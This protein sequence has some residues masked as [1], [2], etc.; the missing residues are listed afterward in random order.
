MHNAKQQCWVNYFQLYS[1]VDIIEQP[2]GRQ[3]P[4]M[5]LYMWV[6]VLDTLFQSP[7]SRAEQFARTHGE[8]PAVVELRQKDPLCRLQCGGGHSAQAGL[9]EGQR[10]SVSREQ[11]LAEQG[12]IAHNLLE[13]QAWA[14]QGHLQSK[15]ANALAS[16]AVWTRARPVQVCVTTTF[17]IVHLY[18]LHLR[19]LKLIYFIIP[20]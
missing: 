10:R 13:T 8:Q 3:W 9:Q 20:V 6:T 16:A 1:Y 17:W 11:V 2:S 4:W 19:V 15:Q 12:S 14:G 7:I 18:Q 5:T